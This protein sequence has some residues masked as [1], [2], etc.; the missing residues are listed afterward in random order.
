MDVGKIGTPQTTMGSGNHDKELYCAEL[1]K[2]VNNVPGENREALIEQMMKVHDQCAQVEP[3]KKV[4]VNLSNNRFTTCPPIP[5]GVTELKLCRTQLQ[6]WP[7]NLPVTLLVL[8][9]KDNAQLTA[10]PDN[11]STLLPQLTWLD[12]SKTS[13]TK[14]PA[15]LP[16]KL[17]CLQ[18]T[19]CEKLVI[20]FDDF[21][22]QLPD[23]T[24]FFAGNS[25]MAH[26]AFSEQSERISAEKRINTASLGFYYEQRWQR[27]CGAASLLLIAFELGVKEMPIASNSNPEGT[28]KEELALT[29]RCELALYQ[30]TSECQGDFTKLESARGSLPHNIIRAGR[31]LGLTEQFYLAE[32]DFTKA[33]QSMSECPDL[34]AEFEKNTIAINTTAMPKLLND[35][36]AIKFLVQIDK[37]GKCVVGK[38]DDVIHCVVVRSNGSYMDPAVGENF[39]SL[40]ELIA[41]YTEEDDPKYVDSGMSIV[42]KRV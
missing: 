27:S 10:L 33:M 38:W 1:Q 42:F 13:I 28:T 6:A 32:N 29:V 15:N 30:I 19:S 34:K 7:N 16:P 36:L 39:F 23:L 4:V 37:L 22:E 17:T 41:N 12:L 35:E 24:S 8:E 21:L 40:N 3:G 25:G 18:V 5:K 14:L 11:L 31:S 9:I 26:L 2:W 20:W